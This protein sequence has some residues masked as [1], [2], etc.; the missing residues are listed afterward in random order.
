MG[1]QQ[2]VIVFK[3]SP[4]RI[5]REAW[6]RAGCWR[7]PTWLALFLLVACGG[8]GGADP[9]PPPPP[10]PP[11]PSADEPGA[12]SFALAAMKIGESAG[13]F[14]LTIL[15]GGGSD[16]SLTASLL[17]TGTAAQGTDYNPVASSITFASGITS[18]TIAITVVN[19]AIHESDETL[20][21]TL[22]SPAASTIGTPSG[23]T[24]TIE[25]D[26][27]PPVIAP[28]GL[29]YPSPLV[30]D[31][32]QPLGNVTPTVTGTVT[33]YSV[34]PG[35][36]L[37]ITL[38]PASGI[39]SGTPRES[40][41]MTSFR[42]NATNQ[43]GTA[44]FDLTLQVRTSF[45]NPVPVSYRPF[46]IDD[47]SHP[48]NG[49]PVQLY[50]WEGR[51]VAILSR[52]A[53]LN[54][55]TMELL[56]SAIDRGYD[57]YASATGRVP[58]RYIH[59]NQKLSIADV[60][61]TCGAGCGYLGFTG[62]E[63]A[64]LYFDDI[65][66]EARLGRY[67]SFLFYELGRNFWFYD[68]EIAY[69]SPL[70]PWPVVT[71]YAVVNWWWSMEAAGVK[72]AGGCG[73]N[74]DAYLEYMAGQLDMYLAN[75]ANNWQ[76]TLGSNIG[77]APSGCAVDAN[78]LFAAFMMRARR[79]YSDDAFP[80]RVWREVDARPNASTTQAA[81]DNLVMATSVAAGKNLVS[82]F[83]ELWRWPLSEAIKAEALAR[84]G[85]PQ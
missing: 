33:A 43:G 31:A 65:Y 59:Y 18:R 35:L 11:P 53:D 12:L 42:V 4:L 45:G 39:L 37:G 72:M 24:I 36:P 64:S 52:R 28:S 85:P 50:A 70:L 71:G 6:R 84:L 14:N 51:N 16:G 20:V 76:N 46:Y 21:L 5:R 79:D 15:R 47:S 3:T 8:G 67:G 30:L 83:E 66:Q 2:E 63:A 23:M 61:T 13:S 69:K 44:T 80:L 74:H 25:D 55:G 77:A 57:Y 49:Q 68:Q 9:A 56:V 7:I 75:T 82:V 78:V 1:I 26:D 73:R 17:V 81:I 32:G 62:I 41:N 60:Q 27:P 29:S 48:Y 58:P 54:P 34:T 19:D 38:D 10:P 40:V 22:S